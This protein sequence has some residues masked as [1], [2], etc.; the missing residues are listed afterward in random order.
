MKVSDG[1]I[2]HKTDGSSYSKTTVDLLLE[3]KKFIA[4]EFGT[5]KAFLDWA[6]QTAKSIMTT[7]TANLH[8]QLMEKQELKANAERQLAAV[9]HEIIRIESQINDSARIVDEQKNRF[10][11]FIARVQQTL[12][13]GGSER[14][15]HLLVKDIKT[16][17]LN[18]A[19]V[20][21]ECIDNIITQVKEGCFGFNDFIA[22][23][24]QEIQDNINLA[25]K[26]EVNT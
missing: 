3:D 26:K 21:K 10:D 11:K 16:R 6:V 5:V 9:T 1:K 8:K 7:E 15:Y 25:S 13:N 23:Q 22:Y 14:A 17:F 19:E 18:E 4:D 24:P 20:D 12:N 2:Y